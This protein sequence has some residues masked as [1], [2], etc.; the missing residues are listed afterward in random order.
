[1]PRA[2]LRTGLTRQPPFPRTGETQALH[3]SRLFI[4]QPQSPCRRRTA[5]CDVEVGEVGKEVASELK[6][7]TRELIYNYLDLC[8]E[9]TFLRKKNRITVETWR[10]WSAGMEAH[11]KKPAFQSIWGE[12]KQESPGSFSFLEQLEKERFSVDPRWWK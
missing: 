10:D 5:P 1:M 7:E 9:Q 12:V 3:C 8:N 11:L 2:H 6:T 4:V